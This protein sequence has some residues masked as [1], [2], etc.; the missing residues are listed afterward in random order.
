MVGLSSISQETLANPRQLS[1][2]PAADGPPSPAGNWEYT[3][4]GICFPLEGVPL[5]GVAG[6]GTA[7][8]GELKEL[9]N[10]YFPLP[11]ELNFWQV[12][13]VNFQYLLAITNSVSKEK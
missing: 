7:E 8:D 13:T 10:Q 12:F 3:V 5:A 1:W 6:G 2:A 4:N 11:H 9:K